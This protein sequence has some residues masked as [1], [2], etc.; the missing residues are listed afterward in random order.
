MYK[1]EQRT[2]AVPGLRG[3]LDAV[4]AEVLGAIE[5]DGAVSADGTPHPCLATLAALV[6]AGTGLR[7]AHLQRWAMNAV[8]AERGER[9]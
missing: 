7:D 1:P 5:R 8:L 4:I 3:R 2:P 9:A 6:P